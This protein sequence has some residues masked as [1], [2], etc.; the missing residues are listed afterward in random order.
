MAETL[1]D[2]GPT[3]ARAP[4]VF[5]M[6][7]DTVILADFVHPRAD[8]QVLDL[9]TGS[10]ILPILL[11]YERPALSLTAIEISPEA[12]SL[13]SENF[14][15]NQ[16]MG[17]VRL[18]RGDLRRY[19]EL[20][21][22]EGFDITVSNPPYFRSGSGAPA[23]GRLRDAREEYLC[24][25][26]ELCAA[27][28]WS[29]R[30]GGSFCLV[31]RPDRLCDLILALRRSGFEP[32]RIRP[33]HHS[34]SHPVNLLLLQARRGGNPGLLWEPDLYLYREDGTESEETRR[35]YR[36]GADRKEEAVWPEC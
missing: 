31:F 24:T 36:R 9:G 12:C 3:L 8:A 7:T 29:T 14:R 34:R 19:R 1:W 26:E 13:A 15:R 27:A 21:P 23:A 32:K 33:V 2:G 5:P 4:G 30:W 35:I 28:A 25:L 18:I 16:M 17:R 6:G 11:G 22:C 10:G 20:L